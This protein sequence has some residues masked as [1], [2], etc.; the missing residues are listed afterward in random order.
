MSDEFRSWFSIIVPPYKKK[1]NLPIVCLLYVVANIVLYYGVSIDKSGYCPFLP[2]S[3]EV[4]EW[5]KYMSSMFLH[6]D[7]IH[8]WMNM[9]MLLFL[10]IPFEVIHGSIRFLIVS[11]VSGVTGILYEQALFH[12]DRKSYLLGASSAVYGLGGSYLSTLLLNYN[13][14]GKMFV[15][16]SCFSILIL[17]VQ[18]VV[19]STIIRTGMVSHIAHTSSF[20]QGFLVNGV[21]GVNLVNERLDTIVFF[22]CLVSSIALILS[23]LPLFLLQPLAT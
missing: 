6:V 7:G 1:Y 20:L 14:M 5:W 4:D 16:L 2:P 3:K 22:L 10:G 12:M 18:T 17:I 23:C 11:F 13:Q 9:I 19:D 15:F 8:L 21:V